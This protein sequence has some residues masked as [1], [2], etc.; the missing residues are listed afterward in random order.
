MPREFGS[1]EE[2]CGM[3]YDGELEK[4]EHRFSHGGE[5]NVC[6]M[7]DGTFLSSEEVHGGTSLTVHS[8]DDGIITSP[9]HIEDLKLISSA[10]MYSQYADRSGKAAIDLPMAEEHWD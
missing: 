4:K 8:P 3:V 1:L 7:G 5:E 6:E 9:G 10:G 2:L